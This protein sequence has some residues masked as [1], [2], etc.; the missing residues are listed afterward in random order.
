MPITERPFHRGVDRI[1]LHARTCEM[2]IRRII[3]EEDHPS[4]L[5][6]P[7]YRA[8]ELF[9]LKLKRKKEKRGTGVA[10][11]KSKRENEIERKR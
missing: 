5:D 1:Y 6:D 8:T 9:V 7:D 3:Q 11:Q 4:T 10:S 2:H